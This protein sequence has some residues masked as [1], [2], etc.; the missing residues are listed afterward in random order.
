MLNSGA[1]TCTSKARPPKVIVN[2]VPWSSFERLANI[3]TVSSD[4]FQLIV[5]RREDGM[6]FLLSPAAVQ[7]SQPRFVHALVFVI[8][9]GQQYRFA[10]QHQCGNGEMQAISD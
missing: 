6:H 1:S 8:I 9:V 5:R 10:S 4:P 3:F 7:I 2:C